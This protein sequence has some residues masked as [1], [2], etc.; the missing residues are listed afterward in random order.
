MAGRVR[1]PVPA[2]P[3]PRGVWRALPAEAAPEL[4]TAR[5]RAPALPVVW[6]PRR[7]PW[8]TRCSCGRSRGRTVAAAAAAQAEV[9]SRT[10]C[11]PDAHPRRRS[12]H[13]AWTSVVWAAAEAAAARW[14]GS[15]CVRQVQWAAPRAQ[16][17]S[18]GQGAPT[19]TMA[20]RGRA[21]TARTAWETR[22]TA[23]APTSKSPPTASTPMARRRSAPLL[24][25]RR[26]RPRK[27][28]GRRA[29]AAWCG[30]RMR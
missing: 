2:A 7:A 30:A 19:T 11:S 16:T 20:M 26:G 18:P 28:R 27:N 15:S 14:A 23:T 22:E 12:H 10:P 8:R 13:R 4:P 21:R 29:L 3:P 17:R 9:V 25:G 24:A 1:G 5:G 6:R